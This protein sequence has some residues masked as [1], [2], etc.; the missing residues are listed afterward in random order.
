MQII[1]ALLNHPTTP[2]EMIDITRTATITKPNGSQ[3]TIKETV[4]AYKA[5]FLPPDTTNKNDGA[6]LERLM[7]GANTKEVY[8]IY[9]FAPNAKEG[10]T[11]YRREDGKYYEV[12]INAFFGSKVNYKP[13]SYTKLYVVLKDNQ[14]G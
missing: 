8:M 4:G 2:S 9:T 3:G 14:R 10:D 1:E 12:K 6:I 11:V 7:S 13:I 5:I